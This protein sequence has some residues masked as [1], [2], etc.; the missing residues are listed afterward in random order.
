MEVCRYFQWCGYSQG[1]W[2]R[3]LWQVSSQWGLQKLL[4]ARIST[5]ETYRL[6]FWFLPFFWLNEMVVLS[7]TFEPDSSESYIS[8]KL[9]FSI[10]WGLSTNFVRCESFLDSNSPDVLALYETT[11]MTPLIL[12]IFLWGVTSNSTGL[13]Y[14]MIL[15]FMWRFS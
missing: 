13:C 15:Q 2:V 14:S 11:W 10:I 9:S 8:L 3:S 4:Q 5:W 1:S 12:A 6:A 7:K